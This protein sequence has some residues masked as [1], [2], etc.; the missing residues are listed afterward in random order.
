MQKTTLYV[1]C[2]YNA[3]TAMKFH[4][5]QR[6]CSLLQATSKHVSITLKVNNNILRQIIQ[7]C[8]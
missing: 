1:A 5:S 8:E 6:K 4:P 2:L 7:L 3:T